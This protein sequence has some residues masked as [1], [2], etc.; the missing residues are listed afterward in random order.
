MIVET[1]KLRDCPFSSTE[2]EPASALAN[3]DRDDFS[4]ANLVIKR[5]VLE[6][7][8]CVFTGFDDHR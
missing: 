2:L 8:A 4:G 1:L 7:E 3:G 6:I 5:L